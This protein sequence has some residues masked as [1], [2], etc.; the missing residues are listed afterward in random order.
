MAKN[1][2]KN[3]GRFSGRDRNAKKKP[4]VKKIGED[5]KE[6]EVGIEEVVSVRDSS[7][8]PKTVLGPLVKEG[9]ITETPVRRGGQSRESQPQTRA[10][11]GAPIAH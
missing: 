7:W 8:V 10:P 11:E 3:K 6:I 5:G 1:M 2:D 9:K 4:M